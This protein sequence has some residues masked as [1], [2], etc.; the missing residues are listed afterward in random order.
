MPDR[1]NDILCVTLLSRTVAN[2]RAII[3]IELYESAGIPKG[4]YTRKAKAAKK[5]PVFDV[6]LNR[7][8]IKNDEK[9]ITKTKK[10]RNAKIIEPVPLR[11]IINAFTTGIRSRPDS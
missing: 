5:A 8:K 1:K 10:Y 9:S 3:P 11:S 4:A 6:F 7:K 2:V